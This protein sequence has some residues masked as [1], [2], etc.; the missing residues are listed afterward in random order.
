MKFI[1]LLFTTA[2]FLVLGNDKGITLN[3]FPDLF[4]VL[5]NDKGITLNMP[6]YLF[7]VLS[8]ENDTTQTLIPAPLIIQFLV[9]EEII[10]NPNEVGDINNSEI[11]A[12]RDAVLIRIR[13]NDNINDISNAH[14]SVPIFPSKEAIQSAMNEVNRFILEFILMGYEIPSGLQEKHDMSGLIAR[15][16]KLGFP[17]DYLEE[18]KDDLDLLEYRSIYDWWVRLW[19]LPTT[20][21]QEEFDQM[22]P[23][24]QKQLTTATNKLAPVIFLQAIKTGN[25]NAARDFVNKA[26]VFSEKTA[27]KLARR[28]ALQERALEWQKTILSQHEIPPR[29]NQ[30]QVLIYYL[31]T[32]PSAKQ[33]ANTLPSEITANKGIEVVEQFIAYEEELQKIK[34]SLEKPKSQDF[35]DLL[36][37]ERKEILEKV[38]NRHSLQWKCMEAISNLHGV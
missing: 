37:E 34:D 20:K 3:T 15:L 17:L 9:S 38:S 19:I 18:A 4:P 27:Q 11:I 8:T 35:K 6:P 7:P 28:I 2:P 14:F 13:A 16:L 23:N 5:G 21:I 12:M 24:K 36:P 26:R 33:I 29:L 30:E 1:F 10:I 32:P 25:L 31:S 22:T